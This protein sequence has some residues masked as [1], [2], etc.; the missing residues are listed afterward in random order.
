MSASKRQPDR[1]QAEDRIAE[2]RDEIRGHDYRYYVLDD[3]AI[4]DADYDRLFRELESLEQAY[5]DLITADSPTQ[6]VGGEPS[7]AFTEVRHEQP[8]LSLGNA[9]EEDELRDFDRRVRERLAVDT[10]VYNAEPKLD[11]LAISLLYEDGVLT[12]GATRGDGT[13][14]EDVTMN[15]R[16][17]ASIPLKLRGD[18]WP[19]RLEVR[20]EVY[21]TKQAF[22]RLNEHQARQGAKRFANP[23]NAAAGSM[24]QL[25]SSIAASR[26][27]NFFAYG[28]GIYDGGARLDRQSRMLAR[29]REWG[30][31]VSPQTEA[32][33]DLAGCFDYYRRIG[34]Q[35]QSLPYDIDGVVFK[36]DRF[37][38]QQQ[39]GFVSRAP[40]WAIAYKYPPEEATTK[41][42]KIEVQVGRTGALTPVARLEPVQV[43]GV[44]VTN[45]T[46]HNED[47]I[48]R[49][50]VRQGDTVIVRRAGDVIPEIVS[51]VLQQRPKGTR[52]F[53]MPAS[54]P[55]CGSEVVRPEGEAVARCSG[56][57]VCPAQR[58]QA[59]IHFASRR[60]MDI[61][62]L[63][64]ALIEQFV[65]EGLLETPAD[66]YRLDTY[67]EQLTEREGWGEKSVSNLLTAID[68]SKST[69]LPRFLYALGIPEVGEVTATELAN[70]F[71]TLEAVE[72][73]ARDYAAALE[74]LRS[75]GATPAEQQKQLKT[76]QLQQVPN[77]GPEVAARLAGFFHESHNRDVIGELRELGVHWPD[78]DVDASGDKPL[79]DRT[80]VLTGTMESMSRDAAR[81]KLEALGA[82]V[83][84][85]VSKKTDYV[86][87][88]ADP[89]S[90]LNKARD[91]GIEILDENGLL[92]LLRQ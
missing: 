52:R 6:R 66:I 14:G 74:S 75:E 30:L 42:L 60:A 50:D 77:I 21:M 10:L 44:T 61:E 68:K 87:A 51:V 19:A 5:P 27:L 34:G 36:V 76:M 35:R 22:L 80:F 29:L 31:P 15:V 69:T 78:I 11:G 7:A 70:H 58:I 13:T 57:L 38:Y 53:K 45:A 79:T 62:G 3:P 86:V 64:E 83:T 48:E 92:E 72:R 67:R 63:G 40:R 17:V 55:E 46:L 49:K 82:K 47:E 56:G 71:G 16:T 85:S 54:C 91:L 41:L 65:E 39:L 81:E 33:T 24:R 4:T 23:R 9:F 12:R 28:V 73:A 20:G 43:G 32:V 59:L 2:L 18:G 25:D 1:E 90:K 84:G 8:M 37:D 26:K 88:G 89:G